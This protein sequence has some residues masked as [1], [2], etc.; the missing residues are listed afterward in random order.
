MDKG[1]KADL[2]LTLSLLEGLVPT[3]R[4]TRSRT[5]NARWS[6]DFANRA[7]CVPGEMK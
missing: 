4:P 6:G 5:T 1:P 2:Q 7:T 3:A